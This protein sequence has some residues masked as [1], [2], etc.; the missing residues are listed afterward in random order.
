MS[1]WSK[2][3]LVKDNDVLKVTELE[4]LNEGEGEPEL[5][6]GWDAIDWSASGA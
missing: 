4:D 2:M 6:D 5:T 1:S 3:G